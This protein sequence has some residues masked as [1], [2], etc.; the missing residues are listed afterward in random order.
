[1][2]D[3]SASSETVYVFNVGSKD[4][5][6]IDATSRKV[7]ETRPLGAQV[8]WLSNEQTYWDGERIWTYDFPDNKV[9]AIA[10]DP[11]SIEVTKSIKDLGTGPAHSLVTLADK[12]KAAVN[13]AGDNVV[14][15][16]DLPSGQVEAKVKTGAFP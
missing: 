9:Q 14:V 16:L 5:T 10:I 8:R 3:A 11:K 2:A 15:F 12:K 13:V 4:V 6:L 1:M 7:K